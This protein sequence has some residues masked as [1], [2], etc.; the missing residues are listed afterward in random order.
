MI[1]L[2]NRLTCQ[3]LP[4][5]FAY[6]SKRRKEKISD[7]KKWKFPTTFEF[8]AFSKPDK[9]QNNAFL[10]WKFSKSFRKKLTSSLFYD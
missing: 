1:F 6:F 2:R 9:I 5:G 7:V 8:S 10:H 4:N 3:N